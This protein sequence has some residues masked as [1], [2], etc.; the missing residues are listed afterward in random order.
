MSKLPIA[1]LLCAVC[2]FGWMGCAAS[3]DPA[4]GGHRSDSIASDSLLPPGARE[5]PSGDA[6]DGTGDGVDDGTDGA[7]GNGVGGGATVS[8]RPLPAAVDS[9]RQEILNAARAEDYEALQAIVDRSPSFNYTFG[10]AHRGG[11]TGYWQEY[12]SDT[13]RP[14]ETLRMLLENSPPVRRDSFFV[15]P[16]W[17]D[18]PLDSLTATERSEMAAILGEEMADRMTEELGYYIGPRTAIHEDGYWVYYVSGD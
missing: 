15:W 18:T 10:P 9:T 7:A 8:G 12:Q 1:W 17:T 4:G 3:D 13:N 14:L 6:D 11:A 2:L 5:G 16:S